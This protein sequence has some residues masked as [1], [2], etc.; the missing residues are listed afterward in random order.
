[1]I[2]NDEL[3]KEILGGYFIYDGCFGFD[4]GRYGFILLFDSEFSR[5]RKHPG[6]CTK[7]LFVKMDE[8]V[9]SRFYTPSICDFGFSTMSACT[10]PEKDFVAVD[11]SRF[12]FSWQNDDE[13]KIDVTIPGIDD[14]V[15]MI[16]KVVRVNQSLYA[17]GSALRVYKRISKEQWQNNLDTL[18]IPEFVIADRNQTYNF[19]DLDGFSDDDMYAVGDMGSVYHFN[20]NMWNQV[21]FPT[22]VGLKTV[23]CAGDGQVYITDTNCSVWAG[24]DVNWKILVKKDKPLSFFDSAFFDGRM[25]FTN[26]DGIWVLEDDQLVLAKNAKSKPIPEDVALLCGRI[27]ISPDKQ[28]MLVCGQRGAAVYDG[29]QWEILFTCDLDIGTKMD[30]DYEYKDLA[31]CIKEIPQNMEKLIKEPFP[32]TEEAVYVDYYENSPFFVN[33]KNQMVISLSCDGV[34]WDETEFPK[35]MTTD[36][37][38]QNMRDDYSIIFDD[39]VAQIKD[40]AGLGEPQIVEDKAP[41]FRDVIELF[42]AFEHLFDNHYCRIAYWELDKRIPFVKYSYFWGDGVY[43]LYVAY[44]VLKKC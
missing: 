28:C 15:C 10:E 16:S 21:V 32:Q 8:P 38:E 24:R 18:P 37:Y 30:E 29:E 1:M 13:N 20:G 14:E 2:F 40:G 25:W 19:H 44:G 42:K 36:D 41:Y 12:V 6:A 5:R 23:T 43:S 35:D 9:E 3:E 17:L 34:D 27:D 22:N 26:D 11:T 7:F 33:N 31:Q 39:A 4:P